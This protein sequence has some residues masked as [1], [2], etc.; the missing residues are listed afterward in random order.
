MKSNRRQFIRNSALAGT[1]LASGASH[2]ASKSR[3]RKITILHTND[4][5]S[6]IEPL[7]ASHKNNPNK[8][9]F[10]RRAELVQQIRSEEKNVMLLDAG[11]FF[12]GT[13]YFNY[14][15]GELEVKLMSALKYD[16]VVL[17]NHEFDNGTIPLYQA[18]KKADFTVLSANY[19]F[20]YKE[21]NK[22]VQPF[23]IFNYEGVNIGVIGLCIDNKNLIDDRNFDGITYSDPIPIAEEIGTFLKERFNCSLVIGLS[24]LGIYNDRKLAAETSSIDLILGGHTHTLLDKPEVHKNKLGK[25]VIINQVGSKGIYLGRLDFLIDENNTI[26]PSD[27]S[28]LT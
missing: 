12:Q 13:P 8:G 9:G 21:W 24:H 1:F 14:F 11:D 17:G 7:P 16:A 27:W 4:V 3:T 19:D 25:D 2:L 15:K 22:L 6:Q 20:I 26:I 23:K 5:H 18:L 10:A 28:K